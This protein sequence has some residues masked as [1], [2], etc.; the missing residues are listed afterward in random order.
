MGFV[1]PDAQNMQAFQERCEPDLPI[2]MLNLLKFCEQARY[3]ND[4]PVEPCSGVEAYRRYSEAVAPLLS[5]YGAEVIW[6]GK[7]RAMLIG[8][9]EEQW[10]LA[11]MVS[12]PRAQSFLDMIGSPEYRQI[13]FHRTSSL[14]DS[15]LLV[16]Q[17]PSED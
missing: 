16:N 1:H 10:D 2:F 3:P 15:R 14:E 4:S 7:P 6:K 8:P 5:Q 9:Q 13:V 11:L 17:E 12:Y